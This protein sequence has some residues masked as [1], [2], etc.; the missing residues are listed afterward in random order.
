[1]FSF[2]KRIISIKTYTR[3]V[4]LALTCSAFLYVFFFDKSSWKVEA[5]LHE[6]CAVLSQEIE[7][8][9]QKNNILSN[10]IAKWQQD[11]FML[12]KMARE[13]L[14]MGHADEIV[15]LM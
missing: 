9:G 13:E 12:E 2:K 3:L 1:M 7:L 14:A 10:E 15:Y 4:A 6:E 5:Q 8:L 11:D